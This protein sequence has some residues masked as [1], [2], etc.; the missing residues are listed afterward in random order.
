MRRREFIAYIGGA[1]AWPL[2][3][4]AQNPERGRHVGV[5]ESLASDDPESQRRIG[6]FEKGLQESGWTAGRN[7]RIEYRWTSGDSENIRKYAAELIARARPRASN[8]RKQS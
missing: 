7:L 6:A 3:G 1:T 8:E 2:A 4:H 5:L